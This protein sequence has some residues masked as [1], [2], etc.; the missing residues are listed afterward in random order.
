M[1]H[2]IMIQIFDQLEIESN[3]FNLIRKSYVKKSCTANIILTGEK[4]NVFLLRSEI[5]L[6]YLLSSFLVNMA[7]KFI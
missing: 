1:Q 6:G 4:M 5:R 7:L 2:S 3:I